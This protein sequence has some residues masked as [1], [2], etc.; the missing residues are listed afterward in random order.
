MPHKYSSLPIVLFLCLQILSI[1]GSHNDLEQRAK[2]SRNSDENLVIEAGRDQNI[3]LRL[4]G[5]TSSLMINDVNMGALLR[6]RQ[7]I[8]AGR[9]AVARRE[10]LSVDAVKDQFRD[11]ERKMTRVQHRV[12][13]SRN[14]TRRSSFSQRNLRRQLQRVERL[15]ATLLTLTTNLAKDECEGSP[16]KNGGSCYDAYLAF[17]CVCAAGWQV[18][19]TTGASSQKRS[20]IMGRIFSLG[21]QCFQV[22]KYLIK[23][24]IPYIRGSYLRG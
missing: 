14:T 13:N 2:I 23:S 4:M 16:C 5:D 17:Q 9:E 20:H 21:S 19:T 22:N 12:F 6:R 8:L 7:S 15:R 3:T 24:I 11:V 18:S 1:K 10:P